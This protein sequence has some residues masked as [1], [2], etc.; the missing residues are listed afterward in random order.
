MRTQ[1][2]AAV[3]QAAL[4]NRAAC[5]LQLQQ[6]QLARQDCDTALQQLLHDAGERVSLEGLHEWITRHASSCSSL[7]H[8]AD[9]DAYNDG[10]D[11]AGS[12]GSGCTADD[13][14]TSCSSMQWG[15]VMRLLSRRAAAWG[16]LKQY[17][18]AA[19]DYEAAAAVSSKMLGDL[20]HA[21]LLRADMARMQHLT[22][23][24]Q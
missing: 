6:Y 13:N 2:D 4:A 17:V 5:H 19:R 12:S 7:L 11:A 14:A 24:A 3:R 22:Q 1:V 15:R 10:A 21:E 16:H 23:C 8:A 9:A 20:Q 18:A